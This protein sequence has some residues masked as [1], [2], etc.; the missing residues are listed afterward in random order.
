MRDTTDI[1][2]EDDPGRL[3]EKHM[4]KKAMQRGGAVGPEGDYDN[5]YT[6]LKPDE[7]I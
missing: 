7:T 3:G 4:E 2:S 1:G 6:S 5:P